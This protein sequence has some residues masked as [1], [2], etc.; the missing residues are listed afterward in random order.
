MQVDSYRSVFQQQLMENTKETAELHK[1]ISM[2]EVEK[3][4]AL[5]EVELVSNKF[6]I[7]IKELEY[8]LTSRQHEFDLEKKRLES[9]VARVLLISDHRGMEL[10]RLQHQVLDR[11]NHSPVPSIQLSSVPSV[12]D[13]IRRPIVEVRHGTYQ[14]EDIYLNSASDSGSVVT[15]RMD[16]RVDDARS[17]S[18]APIN[19]VSVLRTTGE[20]MHQGKSR[21]KLPTF[22][23]TGGYSA[24]QWIRQFEKL[25]AYYSWDE[26]TALMEMQISMTGEAYTVTGHKE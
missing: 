19:P 5:N 18:S 25:C 13:E 12:V 4:R 2:L 14:E 26:H 11:P 8:M 1:R 16:Q 6:K 23:A 3:A 17:H 21:H 20:T 15:A 10:Q 9:E 22:N 24:H 7:R